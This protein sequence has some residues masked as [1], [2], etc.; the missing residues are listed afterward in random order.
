M[1]IKGMSVSSAR[2]LGLNR[3]EWFSFVV[4]V[5]AVLYKESEFNGLKDTG[6]TPGK[7]LKIEDLTE[8]YI[9]AL[10]MDGD[11]IAYTGLRVVPKYFNP[12]LNWSDG[13]EAV[14]KHTVYK[15]LAKN[16]CAKEAYE[17]Y[18]SIPEPYEWSFEYKEE[19]IKTNKEFHYERGFKDQHDTWLNHFH[20]SFPVKMDFPR[21]C[22]FIALN[23][24]VYLYDLENRGLELEK[25]ATLQRD[26]DLVMGK[27]GKG[28]MPKLIEALLNKSDLDN[29]EKKLVLDM[30]KLV[31]RYD[32]KNKSAIQFNKHFLEPEKR[33][34]VRIGS[35]LCPEFK[36][37]VEEGSLVELM[38]YHL[39]RNI[40]SP[41]DNGGSLA[42]DND[43]K[44][45]VTRHMKHY[46]SHKQLVMEAYTNQGRESAKLL[47]S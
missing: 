42:R 47:V 3:E 12:E 44:K 4:L 45:K 14:K 29:E 11:H 31:D 41:P 33:F 24:A 27:T 37:E 22:S 18:S 23:Y 32:L 16:Q 5:D 28:P 34:V 21:Y 15:V 43:L 2:I 13:L 39:I 26:R 46:Y 9:E 25:R 19:L 6:A 38:V 40:V 20:D 30:L 1:N 35:R 10:P 8:G 17:V 36:Y 7:E